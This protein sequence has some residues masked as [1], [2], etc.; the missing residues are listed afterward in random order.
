MKKE[1]KRLLKLAEEL[2][3]EYVRLTSDGHHLMQ[4][5]VTRKRATIPSTPHGGKRGVENCEADLKRK[6]R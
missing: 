5:K 2:G 3:Y 4:H 6:A 1:V